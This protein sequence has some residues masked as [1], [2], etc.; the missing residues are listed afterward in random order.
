MGQKTTN[1]ANR[2]VDI[3]GADPRARFAA[4]VTLEPP[5]KKSGIRTECGS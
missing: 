1:V 5:K 2:Y 4:R 3:A